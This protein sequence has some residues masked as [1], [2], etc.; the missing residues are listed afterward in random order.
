MNET[1]NPIQAPC[2]S[3]SLK[4][5]W[6]H[7]TMIPATPTRAT[8]RSRRQRALFVRRWGS[9]ARHRHTATPPIETMGALGSSMSAQ[10]RRLCWRG[11]ARGLL[12]W[13]TRPPVHFRTLLCRTIPQPHRGWLIS[14]VAPRQ[15]GATR[16]RSGGALAC[17][18]ASFSLHNRSLA[19]TVSPT[20]TA[21]SAITPSPGA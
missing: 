2:R 10:P 15:E 14:G 19:S 18:H 20:C 21:I 13:K 17:C 12:P 11:Q 5:Y 3:T 1:P 7:P 16:R 6:P 4:S 9:S 8:R